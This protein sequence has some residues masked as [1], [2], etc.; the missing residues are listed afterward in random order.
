MQSVQNQTRYSLNF[1]ALQRKHVAEFVNCYEL[2]C[3]CKLEDSA[4][5]SESK[6][7][8]WTKLFVMYIVMVAVSTLAIFLLEH[9]SLLNA[10]RTAL[11][12]AIGKTFAANWVSTFFGQVLKR[13]PS[14]LG[15]LPAN[16]I[17]TSDVW[18]NRKTV[19]RH[20]GYYHN[21]TRFC[22]RSIDLACRVKL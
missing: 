18:A 17:G 1:E 7:R 12:A 3:Q 16:G 8:N 22:L 13:F 19:F 14:S 11:V 15:K 20:S 4:K 21:R 6:T 10:F 2:A 9:S 5:D